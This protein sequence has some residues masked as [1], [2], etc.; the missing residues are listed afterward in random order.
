MQIKW[1][2]FHVTLELF[3][4]LVRGMWINAA[5]VSLLIVDFFR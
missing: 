2:N 3:I 5:F 4:D 1:A